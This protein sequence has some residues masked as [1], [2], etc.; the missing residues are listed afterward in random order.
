VW[1][2]FGTRGVLVRPTPSTEA[3]RARERRLPLTAAVRERGDE[4][5]VRAER[6]QHD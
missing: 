5:D 1:A 6:Q 3:D 2:D 4:R